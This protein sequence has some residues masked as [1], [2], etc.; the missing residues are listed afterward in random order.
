M[1][2]VTAL[3]AIEGLSWTQAVLVMAGLTSLWYIVSS[4]VVWYK[5]RHIPGPFFASFSYVWA[6]WVSYSGRSHI[7]L[8][9]EKKKYGHLFRIGPDS[10]AVSDSEAWN[11]INSARSLFTRGDW[12]SSARVDYRGSSVI[13]ELDMAKHGKRKSK[14][15]SAFSGKHLAVLETKVDSWIAALIRTIHTKIANGNET[16]DIGRVIQY[17]QVDLI[18]ELGMGKAWNDLAEDKDQFGY[19][20]MSDYL[21][22][23]IQSFGFLPLARTLYTSTWFMKRF[24]PKTTDARGVGLFLKTLEKEV[25][26]RFNSTIPKSDQSQD[27][28]DEWMKHG[29]PEIEC[30]LD[31]SLLVPAGSETSAMMIRGTLLHLMSSPV[32]YQKLKQEIRDEIAAGRISNPVTNE[33]A[34]SL[35]YMQAV[36]RE[37]LRIMVPVNFGF[38]KRV[39]ASGDTICGI[40]L[41]AG[42]DVYVNYHSMMRSQEIF[43]EDADTFRPERF[44][45][46]GPNV[47]QMIKTIELAFGNGRFMC[48]GKVLAWLEMN[49][50]FIELLRNFDF[51]VANP[52]KPW[53]RQAYTTWMVYDFWARVT[54]DTTM[55]EAKRL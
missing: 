35:E 33:E 43:G 30:Q 20:E 10:V 15:A 49:K 22:P 21:I 41:P 24:G 16:M 51:Q 12:Y 13:T 6:F 53:E 5:L 26:R 27:I 45:G 31:L 52:E 37:G 7:I 55:G 39:P 36:V 46:G 38:P 42:T 11:Q 9:N 25:T 14:L 29:L 48:L 32:I 23:A 1:L 40:F 44:L 34:K 2:S 47:A 19:L 8:H 50:L 4:V 28:L 17:F 54:E 18:S 3:N